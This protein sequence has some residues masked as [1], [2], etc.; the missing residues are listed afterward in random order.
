MCYIL[1][2]TCS[3]HHPHKSAHILRTRYAQCSHAAI[4]SLDPT[5]CPLRMKRRRISDMGVCERCEERRSSLSVLPRKS[6]VDSLESLESRKRRL[7]C[8]VQDWGM[9]TDGESEGEE[10]DDASTEAITRYENGGREGKTSLT[11]SSHGKEDTR[12]IARA[13]EQQEPR[14]RTRKRRAI[15]KPR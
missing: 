11:L 12:L 2:S 5:R 15:T 3:S 8:A 6:L 9:D 10:Q 14:Q 13:L 4:H 7:S 1:V